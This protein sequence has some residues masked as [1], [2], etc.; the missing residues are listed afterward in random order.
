MRHN[1]PGFP[2]E[3]S[4]R[5]ELPDIA[6]LL[7]SPAF[8]G[9]A[10]EDFLKHATDFQRYLFDRVPLRND[11]KYVLIRSGVWLLEPG[12]RSHVDSCGEWHVD[13]EGYQ[14]D[15][16]N[17]PE[18]FFLLSS[19]CSALTEFNTFPLEVETN[20]SQLNR[21]LRSILHD[22]R[23]KPLIGKEIEPNRIYTVEKHIHR[24]VD[25]TRIEFRFFFRVVESDHS[26]PWTKAPLEKVLLRRCDTREDEVNV[27]YC[28][29]GV[30]IR[31]PS[32][33]SLCFS[34]GNQTSGLFGGPIASVER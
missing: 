13:T 15:G 25:P 22:D 34:K 8:Q 6:E 10:P 5:I 24:A 19:S 21:A 14:H 33:R 30:E 29:K 27:R 3:I 26:F 7:I 23:A 20:E 4:T 11:K 31:Y 1:F 9:I 12:Y 2:D 17:N 18:R 28:D 32:A 16:Q